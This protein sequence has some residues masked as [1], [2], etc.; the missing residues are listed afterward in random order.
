MPVSCSV[1]GI[2]GQPSASRVG[3]PVRS[4]P[5]AWSTKEAPPPGDTGPP[6]PFVLTLGTGVTEVS[7]IGCGHRPSGCSNLSR[8]T[9]RH[10]SDCGQIHGKLNLAQEMH[11][12]GEAPL[13]GADGGNATKPCAALQSFLLK[14][15]GLILPTPFHHRQSQPGDP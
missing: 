6:R 9:C 14:I 2:G 13:A 15:L 11:T 4:L 10:M 5:V 1:T 7:L 3:G 8:P 12:S